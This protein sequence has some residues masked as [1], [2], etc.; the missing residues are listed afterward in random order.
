MRIEVDCEGIRRNAEAVV[1]MCAEHGIRVA[2][3]TKCCC[4][5]PDIARAMLAGGVPG[6]AESRLDN[7]RRLRSAGI[8]APVLLLRLPAQ[9]EADQVVAL[10]QIS[11]NSEIETVQALG[12]AAVSQGLTHRVVLMVEMGDRREGVMPEDASAAAR[13]MAAVDGVELIG[14]ATSLSCIGGVLPTC[15]NM[16]WF[17][18]IVER[19][20]Q[21]LGRPFEIV[22]GG[23]TGNLGFVYRGEMPD[24]INHLRV[25]EGILFGVDSTTFCDLPMPCQD[26]FKVFAEVIELKAKPSMPSGGPIGIDAFNRVPTWEDHG[27]RTR[28][29]LAVGE[30]DLQTDCLVPTRPGI[31]YVGASSDHLVLDVTDAEPPVCLG[32]ELEF[33][34]LY[35]AI[36]TGW[37]SVNTTKV[38]A[39]IAARSQRD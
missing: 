32:E 19:L 10:A 1:S 3:V 7:I 16:T 36:S 27:I 28:A 6:L 8:D 26:T 2:G 23:H 24:R 4:G 18:D 30:I 20:E 17:I 15:E 14:I 25:G 21:D 9:S 29:I 39:P 37:S 33:G 12:R 34:V 31:S 5:E 13:A 35:P 22:S 11:L 38:I